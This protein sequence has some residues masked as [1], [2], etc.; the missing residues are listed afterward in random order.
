MPK[1]TFAITE[2]HF[3]SDLDFQNVYIW[4]DQLVLNC[5][6]V[7]CDTLKGDP[8]YQ[9][10]LAMDHEKNKLTTDKSLNRLV[11]T[12]LS[13]RKLKD[14][15]CLPAFASTAVLRQMAF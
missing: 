6:K 13:M 15:Y 2:G 10:R 12:I 3:F 5:R 9:Y 11:L 1:I 8:M 4:I 14:V 7:D